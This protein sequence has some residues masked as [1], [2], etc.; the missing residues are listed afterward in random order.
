MRIAILLAAGA[1][2]LSLAAC[3]SPQDEAAEQQA[4]ALEQ[5]ADQVEQQAGATPAEQ[6]AVD[7]QAEALEKKADQVEEQAGNADG[8]ATT[9]NTPAGH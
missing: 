2:A 9:G 3:N 8:G 4:D 7:A 1:A 6:Q 5:Q